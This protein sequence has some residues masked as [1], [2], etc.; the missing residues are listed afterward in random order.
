[1]A[2]SMFELLA[3]TA[4]STVAH[5]TGTAKRRKNRA[6]VDTSCAIVELTTLVTC[7]SSGV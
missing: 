4:D 5:S 2:T 6:H 7:I 3:A 1:M